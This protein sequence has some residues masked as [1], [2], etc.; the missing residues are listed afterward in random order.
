MET[1]KQLV[2]GISLTG[3]LFF[4]INASAENTR[5]DILNALANDQIVNLSIDAKKNLRGEKFYSESQANRWRKENCGV[6]RI[7]CLD[8]I[9]ESVKIYVG[10]TSYNGY[11]Y[12][13]PWVKKLF[14]PIH[15]SSGVKSY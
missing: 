8:T 4:S 2:T 10:G 15:S 13:V 7:R 9:K 3:L 1:I 11:V 5:P 12:K 14:G 6:G